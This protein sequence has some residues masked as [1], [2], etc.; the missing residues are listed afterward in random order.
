MA[1]ASYRR[2]DAVLV[3]VGVVWVFRVV[4]N[5]MLVHALDRDVHPLFEMFTPCLRGRE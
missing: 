5:Q 3:V 4:L 1:R 2:A